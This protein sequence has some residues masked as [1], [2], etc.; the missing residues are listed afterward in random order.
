[1]TDE[2]VVWIC[3]PPEAE[4]IDA[5]TIAWRAAHSYKSR[6][7]G[8]DAFVP[9]PLRDERSAEL[10]LVGTGDGVLAYLGPAHL[11]A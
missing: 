6:W 5:D 4:C 1:M 8:F 9:A 11:S 2:L 7:P 10:H 3:A